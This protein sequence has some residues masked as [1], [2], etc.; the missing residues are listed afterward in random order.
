MQ[1]NALNITELPPGMLSN[2]T[3]LQDVRIV[4]FGLMSISRD[5]FQRSYTIKNIDLSYNYLR[6]LPDEL[7]SGLFFFE[8]L[9]I[10][11]NMF[12]VIPSGLFHNLG[13]LKILNLER[14]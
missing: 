12:E 14:N 6:I 8:S 2:L 4:K 7:F 11:G 9:T 13:Q 1:N 3:Q 5:T 10:Q